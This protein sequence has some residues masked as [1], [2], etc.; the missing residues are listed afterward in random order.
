MPIHFACSQ[1]ARA[2][3]A[4]DQYAGRAAR[5]PACGAANTIPGTPD[6]TEVSSKPDALLIDM[7]TSGGSSFVAPVSPK[8]DGASGS[9]MRE[10]SA[11]PASPLLEGS[12]GPERPCPVCAE[13]IQQA[14]RK[15][16]FCGA[17]LDDSLRK[18]QEQEK[19]KSLVTS[20][21]A[22][23]YRAASLWRSIATIMTTCTVGWMIW[24][25]LNAISRPDPPYAV[26]VFNAL[27]LVGLVWSMRQMKQGPPQ[28]F[29]AAACAVML[30]MPLD[31]QMGFVDQEMINNVQKQNETQ[32]VKL[33]V[34]QA[35]AMLFWV[36]MIIGFIF[37]VPVWIA[38]IKV[39]TLQRLI[40]EFGP[41]P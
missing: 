6:R 29:F 4:Q 2:M 10:A 34:D 8:D 23:A 14:A 15:C 39:A 12:A 1:C 25:T 9:A 16:R 38:A 11:A 7:E 36:S 20:M 30:C 19:I 32:N 17:V 40:A 27:L 26:V 3:F 31:M 35:R 41:K 5:C 21:I 37:S 28:V 13:R 24:L 18:E 22:R 33:S